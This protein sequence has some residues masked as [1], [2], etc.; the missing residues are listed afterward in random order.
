MFRFSVRFSLK[1]LTQI[2][3][4]VILILK[5]FIIFLTTEPETDVKIERIMSGC[6]DLRDRKRQR[7]HI[8]FE[9]NLHF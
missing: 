4:T 2:N 3:V 6:T 9:L 1:L 8:L 7:P 5:Y